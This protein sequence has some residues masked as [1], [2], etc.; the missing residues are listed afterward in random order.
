[1]QPVSLALIAVGIVLALLGVVVLLL[2]IRK[3]YSL[4]WYQKTSLEDSKLV[5]SGG[6]RVVRQHVTSRK[7][8]SLSTSSDEE[9]GEDNSALLN[10]DSD[11]DLYKQ[12][13]GLFEKLSKHVGFIQ[14]PS[15]LFSYCTLWCPSTVTALSLFHWISSK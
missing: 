9:L 4:N 8:S 10:D 5:N 14:P 11:D 13:H 15:E 3:K 12:R 2:I 6:L 7:L 1:M